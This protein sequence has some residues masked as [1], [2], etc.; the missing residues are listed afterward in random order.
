ML[1]YALRRLA[2]LPLILVFVSTLTFVL[3]RLPFAR[4]PVPLMLGMDASQQQ[5]DALRHD[6]ELDRP[7]YIQYGD[8]IGRMV[9]GDLGKTFR[10]NQSVWK[11]IERR[12]PVTFEVAILA[13]AISNTAGVSVGVLSAIKQN[14]L[15]DYV[16][17]TAAV[18]G[19]SIPE[20]F[21]LVLLIV[22]P[23]ILWNYSPPV[24]GHISILKD[25]LNN[26]RLYLPAAALLGVTHAAMMMRLTRSTLLEVFRQDYVR[27]ARSK[28]LHERSVIVRHSLKNASIPLFTALGSQIAALF[29]GSLIFEQIFSVQGVGQ[30]F[31][32][33]LQAADMPVIQTLTLYTAVVIV[34]INLIVDLSYTLMDPRVVY[35]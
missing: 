9:R 34:S 3:L 27:T 33:S 6:L 23:S 25:P 12:V 18:F 10:G 16:A 22:I 26:L 7:I 2:Y 8:W 17:R 19:Q 14:S 30:F 35:S 29:F 24:G 31:F 28:G 11:E 13:M 4:D 15:P 5:R 20:F 32:T 21:L 1:R